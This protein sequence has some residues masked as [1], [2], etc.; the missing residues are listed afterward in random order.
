VFWIQRDVFIY[1]G[2]A[3]VGVPIVND[4]LKPA[5]SLNSSDND[6]WV[7]TDWGE[8]GKN[9]AAAWDLSP[10]R[11]DM[12]QYN[13]GCYTATQRTLGSPWSVGGGWVADSYFAIIGV[14]ASLE[15]PCGIV[16]ATFTGGE[17]YHSSGRREGANWLCDCRYLPR[18]SSYWQ[19]FYSVPEPTA[20]DTWES[21]SY[22][23]SD[24]A[25]VASKVHL[26]SWRCGVYMAAS[27]ATIDLYSTETPDHTI[28]SE[29]ANYSLDCTITNNTTGE[30]IE[31]TY[32][33]AVNKELEIDTDEHT[34]IDLED[35]SRQIQALTLVGGA[36]RHW[37]P[38]QTGT[39]QLQ[40]DDAGTAGVTI[41][42]EW[43][44]RYRS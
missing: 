5:F 6:S 42:L 31:V 4:N 15:N 16:N 29:Q 13:Y 27:G 2:N 14:G 8:D 43:Y 3:T 35:D 10:L 11:I 26:L 39:N 40:F 36:R 12:N 7:Y 41:T 33:M 1:Y 44:E 17:K 18:D 21:W 37:L 38:L 9:R 32:T 23:G 24:F 19:T 22:S 34:V 25:S 30:A 20:E 28:Y